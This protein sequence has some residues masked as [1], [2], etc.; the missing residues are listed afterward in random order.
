V[1][2][3][4]GS[5]RIDRGE[6]TAAEI[7]ALLAV[8]AG[9]SAAADQP[10]APVGRNRLAT[11]SSIPQPRSWR[12]QRSPLR[13]AAAER[14]GWSWSAGASRTRQSERSAGRTRL[15]PVAGTPVAA[16]DLPLGR[17]HLA[18]ATV[19]RSGASRTAKEE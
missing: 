11:L 12:W 9:R 4:A 17:R 15:F 8:L 10:D 18:A 16:A 19:T 3:P 7:A 6:P 13:A 2:T 1:T 14:P 5:L